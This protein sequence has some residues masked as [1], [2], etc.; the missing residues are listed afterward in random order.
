MKTIMMCGDGSPTGDA[1]LS[2]AVELARQTGASLEVLAVKPP[3]PVHSHGPLEEIEEIGGASCIAWRLAEQARAGGV[4][5]TP[6]VAHGVPAKAI[7]RTARELDA[8]LVVVGSRGLGSLRSL[9]RG[10]VSR[11]VV[12]HAKIPVTVVRSRRAEELPA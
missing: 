3:F 1:A 5:A 12:R 10:S 4:E 11:D 6:R 7:A 9:L 2:F 8:D